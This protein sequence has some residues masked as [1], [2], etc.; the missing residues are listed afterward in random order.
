MAR[1]CPVFE[2]LFATDQQSPGTEMNRRDF[3]KAIAATGAA[4]GPLCSFISPACGDEPASV[5]IPPGAQGAHQVYDF[6][7]SPYEIGFQHGK[8]LREEIIRETKSAVDALARQ[9]ATSVG[10]ALD[11]V[12]SSYEPLFR[13]H[14]PMALEEIRGMAQGS[15]LSYAHAFFVATRVGMR[16]PAA[17]SAECTAVACGK[18][19]T[20]GGK[21]FIGQNKDLRNRPLDRFRIMRVAYDSGRR[22]IVLN[23]AGWIANMCLT[24]D[25]LSYTGNSLYAQ[26]ASGDVIPFS[27]LIRLVLEKRSV[28]EVLDTIPKLPFENFCILIGDATGHLVCLEQVAGQMNIRDVSQD[29]FGHANSILCEELKPF[30]DAKLLGLSSPCRQKNVQQRLD[31]KRGRLT[32]ADLKAIFAD[33]ADY[34]LSIC[35][36]GDSRGVMTTASFVANLTDRE[37]EIAIGHPCT[38]PFRRYTL[39]F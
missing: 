32:V 16:V 14:A 17:K 33:H 20:A 5:P 15:E 1:P 38:A 23:Y 22:G 4:G 29:A 7:G 25:G 27:L 18:P 6:K 12:V 37:I 35:R 21:V 36:H 28:R 13:D 10:K 24:S 11:F 3:L 9:R 31:E 8:R 34:P 30:E 26:E 2:V 19:T 39:D